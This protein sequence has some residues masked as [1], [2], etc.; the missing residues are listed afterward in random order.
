MG[1]WWLD[2]SLLERL[3]E[4]SVNFLLVFHELLVGGNKT[5]NKQ[6]YKE[7][8]PSADRPLKVAPVLVRCM[9]YAAIDLVRRY[10]E[11]NGELVA[12]E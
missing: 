5:G 3:R 8:T 10:D 2:D 12:L 4:R 9:S 7:N 11:L 1:N 6:W